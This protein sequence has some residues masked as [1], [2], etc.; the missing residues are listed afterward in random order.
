MNATDDILSLVSVDVVGIHTA[1]VGPF[2]LKSTFLPVYRAEE[3]E[4][5]MAALIGGA[6]FQL[7][8][9]AVV[10]SALEQMPAEHRAQAVGLGRALVALNRGNTGVDGLD[11]IVPASDTEADMLDAVL[12]GGAENV[13]CADFEPARLVCELPSADQIGL[14]RLARNVASF[15]R[16]NVGIAM[17]GFAGSSAAI[18]AVRAIRPELVTIET[19]WFRQVASM[20]QAA[21]LLP[22]LFRSLRATGA[23]VHVGGLDNN[24]QIADALA[25]GADL[26]SGPALASPVPAGGFLAPMS[27]S[28]EDIQRRA[29]NIVPLFG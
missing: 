10:P 4:L 5:R 18:E 29:N 25:A 23:S 3:D 20:A 12:D 2:V 21:C 27:L 15:R 1:Q 16:R 11:V 6:R 7:A 28:V 9:H 14:E 17:R 24:A 26:L 22:G 13:T 8:G 19:R